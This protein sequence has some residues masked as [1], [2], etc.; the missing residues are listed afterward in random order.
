ME[1]C[2]CFNA[3]EELA[4]KILLNNPTAVTVTADS[5]LHIA[6]MGNLRIHSVLS[7]LPQPD[8]LGQYE[9]LYPPAQELYTFNRYGQHLSTRNLITDQQVYNFTYNVNSY[10]G[11]LMKIMD[12]GGNAI[13][14]RRDYKLQAKELVPPNG[15]RCKFT[16]DNMGLLQE[17]ATADNETWT[18]GY[19]GNT[20]L[21]ESKVASDGTAV[22]YGYDQHGRLRTL[23]H[24][25]GESYVVRTDVGE[26]G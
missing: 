7:S 11:K 12:G 25:T 20:G 23:T 26:P 6:D 17:F 2:K 8:R 22:L 24:P 4:T 13:V 14:V 21:V 15:Q 18:F 5:T 3:R 1:E 16:T 10:Y 9:V 19:V